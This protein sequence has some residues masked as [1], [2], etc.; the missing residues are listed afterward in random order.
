M[1]YE[2]SEVFDQIIENES[3]L[4]HDLKNRS[5]TVKEY[6]ERDQKIDQQMRDIGEVFESLGGFRK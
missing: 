6:L 5:L 4:H 1:V 3:Q 2:T